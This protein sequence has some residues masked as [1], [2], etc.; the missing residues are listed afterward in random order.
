MSLNQIDYLYYYTLLSEIET[1]EEPNALVLEDVEE[2]AV[3]LAP[4][5]SKKTPELPKP[6]TASKTVLPPASPDLKKAA[7]KAD[8]VNTFLQTV[9]LAG[10]PQGRIECC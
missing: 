4:G 3:S 6:A 10:V 5:I 7:P 9:D 1:G 2:R 8:D